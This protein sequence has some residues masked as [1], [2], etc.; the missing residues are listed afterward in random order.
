M[1]TIYRKAE[2]MALSGV[3]LSG[4]VLDLGGHKNSPYRDLFKGEFSITTADLSSEADIQCNFEL[5]LPISDASY[6]GVLL[7]N[8]LEHIFEYRQLIGEC[9][10][11]LK[12]RGTIIIAVPFLFPY[13]ASPDDFHR[14]TSTALERTLALAGFSDIH[15]QSLGSGVCAVRWALVERLLPGP[16]RALSLVTVPFARFFDG[17]ITGFARAFGKKYSPSDYSLGYVASA[18]KS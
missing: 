1:T 11:V 6:D 12:P 14:Y 15:V 2:H 8:V 7:I 17:I 9:A 16:F 3:T 5:P 4:K 10:R 18:H 13:H